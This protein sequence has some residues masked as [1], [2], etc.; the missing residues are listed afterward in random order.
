VISRRYYLHNRVWFT[1]AC[2]IQFR[3]PLKL[4]EILVQA[5]I[6]ALSGSV[7]KVAETWLNMKDDDFFVL[8]KMLPVYRPTGRGMRP[9]DLMTKEYPEVW[10]LLV[11]DCGNGLGAYHVVGLF[12]FGENQDLDSP[13]SEAT[14]DVR[15]AFKDIGLDPK[16]EYL[17]FE[18][19]TGTFKGSSTGSF[20][21]KLDPRNVAL[22]VFRECK[23]VPQF[24]SSNRHFTQGWADVVSCTWNGTQRKIAMSVK[25]V[26]DHEHS[27]DFHV[28]LPYKVTK[29]LINGKLWTPVMK[30]NEHMN[31]KVMNKE[32]S[33]LDINIEFTC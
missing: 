15:M 7:F 14:R 19:W 28:P 2:A 29:V 18:F 9:A 10:D 1:H 11:D 4:N 24:L 22:L 5:T 26:Q 30:T 27:L 25:G 23:G 17:A 21:I 13:L 20:T 8:S 3:A 16:K 12:N 32:A 6:I 33:M 31:V